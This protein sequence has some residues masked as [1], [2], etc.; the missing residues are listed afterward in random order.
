MERVDKDLAQL[1]VFTPNKNIGNGL[2]EN[3]NLDEDFD[4]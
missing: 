4:H 1:A 2:D 3:D